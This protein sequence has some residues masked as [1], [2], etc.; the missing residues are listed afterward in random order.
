[1]IL[2]GD[3]GQLLPVCASSLYNI[4]FKGNPLA[5]AG[6]LAYRKFQIV[7]TLEAIMRQQNSDNDPNQKKF[8]E[9]LP[10]LRNGTSTKEDWKLL[11]T[12][13][14]I[15]KNNLIGFENAIHIFNDNSSVN[16]MNFEKLTEMTTP[17]T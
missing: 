7:I 14:S 17:I 8:I 12:R 13:S 9:L 16:Q 6:Y 4:N 10:R 5:M 1:M 11:L 15:N 2:I 3:P